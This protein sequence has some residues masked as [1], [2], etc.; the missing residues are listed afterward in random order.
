M[1]CV[2]LKNVSLSYPVYGE[3]PGPL[4]ATLINLATGGHLNKNRG[5]ITVEALKDVN[6]KL[7]KGDRL[8]LIGHN[9]AGK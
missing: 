3:T 6:I 1:T 5:N 9:G 7:E 2:E 8:A 4:K